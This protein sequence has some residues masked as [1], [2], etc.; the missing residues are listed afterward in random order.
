MSSIFDFLFCSR[1]KIHFPKAKI[2]DQNPV[3]FSAT[4]L[5]SVHKASHARFSA[6]PVQYSACGGGAGAAYEGSSVAH[7]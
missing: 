2:F 7:T 1:V 6:L 5:V 3:H 4:V